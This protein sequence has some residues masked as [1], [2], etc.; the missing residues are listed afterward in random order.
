MTNRQAV[1][2]RAGER[3]CR[4]DASEGDAIFIVERIERVPVGTGTDVRIYAG[5]Q[6]FMAWEV[7]GYDARQGW[8][9]LRRASMIASQTTT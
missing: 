1:K 6:V 3:V 8:P 7:G 4:K 2:L 9:A 5:G